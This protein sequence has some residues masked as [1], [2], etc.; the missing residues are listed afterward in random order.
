MWLA[1]GAKLGAPTEKLIA[2]KGLM[3][4]VENARELLATFGDRIQ[5]PDDFA[6][7]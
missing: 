1:K 2:D 5:I 3:P 6:Y 7:D 4:F